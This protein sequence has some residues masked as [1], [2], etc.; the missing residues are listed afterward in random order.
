MVLPPTWQEKLG[1]SL[2]KKK[3]LLASVSPSVVQGTHAQYSLLYKAGKGPLEIAKYSDSQ[4][5]K[6]ILHPNI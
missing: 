6:H 2:K 5:T 3:P 1:N 4:H